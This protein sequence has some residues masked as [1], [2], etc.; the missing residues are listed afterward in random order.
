MPDTGKLMVY[1]SGGGF[2]VRFTA[3]EMDLRG[4]YYTITFTPCESASYLGNYISG[5]P[6]SKMDKL[7]KELGIFRISGTNIPFL[8]NVVKHKQFLTG[9]Y[10]TSF[11]DSTPELFLFPKRLDRGTKI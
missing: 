5:K 8:E 4:C 9:D 3:P 10:D 6:T 7:A 2:G 11:I 1:R